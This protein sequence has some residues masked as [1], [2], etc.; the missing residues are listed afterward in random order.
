[1]VGSG[2]TQGQLGVFG[3]DLGLMLDPNHRL[4]RLAGKIPW[5]QIEA[6]LRPRYATIGRPSLPIRLLVGLTILKHTFNVSDE[7]LVE[8][9]AQ[10][11]TGSSSAANRTS[12]GGCP[13]IPRR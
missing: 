5:A 13:V 8:T 3:N 10:N 7:E 4:N 11:P 2:D 9:R 1:M 6:D 12:N